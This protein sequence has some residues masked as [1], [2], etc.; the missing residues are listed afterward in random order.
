[1]DRV[2]DNKRSTRDAADDERIQEEYHQVCHHH[3][4]QAG[5]GRD[6]TTYDVVAW[7]HSA[8][9]FSLY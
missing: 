7:L 1:M 8:G 9:Y 5:I 2:E 3:L 4:P 6:L